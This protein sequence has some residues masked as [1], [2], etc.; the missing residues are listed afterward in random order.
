M[1]PAYSMVLAKQGGTKGEKK[2]RKL[3]VLIAI[4]A[5]VSLTA[6]PAAADVL[7]HADDM[8]CAHAGDVHACIH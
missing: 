6:S 3:K 4:L 5:M 2:L 7:A 8:D 1:L